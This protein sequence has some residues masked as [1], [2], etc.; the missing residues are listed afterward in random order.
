MKDIYN[1]NDTYLESKLNAETWMS[2][3]PVKYQGRK[4]ERIR[5]SGV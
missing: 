2:R 4:T 3:P 5:K 1:G